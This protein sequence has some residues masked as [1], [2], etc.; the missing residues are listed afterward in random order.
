MVEPVHYHYGKF[1]P[2]NLDLNRLLPWVEKAI[3]AIAGYDGTLRAIPDPDVLLSPLLTNEAVLSSRIEGTRTT[4]GEVLEFEAGVGVGSSKKR[5]DIIEVLNYRA[6]MREAMS[7]MEKLPLSLRIVKAT[8]RVLMQGVRGENK[9]PGEFR[10]GPVHIGPPDSMIENARFVPIRGE[11]VAKA[12]S[13]WERY[14]HSEAQSALIQLAISHAEFES[15]HPFL[16][17]NGRVGRL[18]IP[19]FMVEKKLITRPNFYMS[20]YLDQYRDTYFERL[21]AVSRD[22]D[23]TGWCEF[24]LIALATQGLENQSKVLKIMTLHKQ[25]RQWGQDVLKSQ[26]AIPA[27]DWFFGNP[28]FSSTAFIEGSGIPAPTARRILRSARESGMLTN[29]R[30]ASGRRPALLTFPEL[31]RVTEGTENS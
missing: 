16:D 10:T 6:A 5:D 17:G 11:E 12:I 23:W 14:L 9:A 27:V 4:M 21:R 19:L 20:G 24:F 2:K 1:P 22:D 30:P 28:I 13:D 8:H 18:L 7:L 31:L 25:K 26:Y 3:S 15:V 29:L